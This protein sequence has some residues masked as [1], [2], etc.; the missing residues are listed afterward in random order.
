MLPPPMR[1]MRSST[2]SCHCL[3]RIQP[4]G[5]EQRRAD[6]HH[7]RAL[8]HGRLEVAAH[9]HR[10]G[11]ERSGRA[12]FRCLE[13]FAQPPRTAARCAPSVEA[14]G[15]SMHIR[16]RSRSR[17]RAATASSQRAAPRPAST[18]PLPASSASCTCSSTLQRRR[19]VRALRVSRSAIALAVD[20]VHPVEVLGHLARLVALQLADEMPGEAARPR[21]ASILASASC[22]VVLA[23]VALTRRAAAAEPR[24]R[25]PLLTAR[26]VTEPT[27]RPARARPRPMRS[28]DPH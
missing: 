19:V 14:E 23:E 21:S 25:L 2:V 17:G 7:R 8:E 4:R 13:Q 5:P 16:P 10:Q 6:A 20:R 28:R 1:A 12:A 11:V 24:R 3:P 9:A 15:G 18:P 27:S 22:D 26:S